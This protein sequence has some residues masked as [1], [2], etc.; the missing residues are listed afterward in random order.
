MLHFSNNYVSSAVHKN[1]ALALS[2]L[3]GKQHVL[4]PIRRQADFE[5]NGPSQ[6]GLDVHYYWY[7]DIIKYFPLLKVFFIFLRSVPRLNA[8]VLRD[9]RESGCI[10]HN[11]WSDGVPVLLLSIV[12]RFKYLVV[13]RNTDINIFIPKLIHYR[14]LVRL[15]ISRSEGLVFVSSAHK[16]RFQKSWPNLFLAARAVEVI[17]N[18]ID[19]FWHEN[20]VTKSFKRPFSACFVGKF[21]EN[22]NL[23]RLLKA[24]ELC[25]A[26]NPQFR[27]VLVGGTETEFLTVTD[28]Q[29]IPDYIDIK[30]HLT[31]RQALAR[32]LQDSRVF[33]MPS[34]RETFGLVFIEALSQGCT[35]ICSRGEGIDGVFDSEYVRSVDSKNHEDIYVALIRMLVGYEAGCSIDWMHEQLD[36]FAWPT[37]AVKYNRLLQ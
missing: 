17:P 21:N 12:F 7:P 5:C 26:D 18:G 23:K 20:R 28:A 10:A 30:G 8:E 15:V 27:L 36:Q 11:L 32:I 34:L 1:L 22:K 13:V 33:I 9:A 2:K 3:F 4:I 16:K 6:T 14:W 37:I 24:A 25:F 35:L 19:G 29:A 31:S